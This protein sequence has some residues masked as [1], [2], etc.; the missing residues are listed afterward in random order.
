MNAGPIQRI[1]AYLGPKGGYETIGD[2]LLREALQA[3]KESEDQRNEMLKVIL[4][5]QHTFQKLGSVHDETRIGW[6]LQ[7]LD[8]YLEKMQKPPK[9][10]CDDLPPSY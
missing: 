8:K 2:E 7:E 3:L 9:P 6:R 4:D 1:Q 10:L 5:C